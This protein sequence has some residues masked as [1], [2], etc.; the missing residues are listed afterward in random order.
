M[1][2]SH[3]RITYKREKLM[4]IE[5]NFVKISKTETVNL[6]ETSRHTVCIHQKV[7]NS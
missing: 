3:Q 6:S 5:I 7:A 4:I 1:Q 2:V